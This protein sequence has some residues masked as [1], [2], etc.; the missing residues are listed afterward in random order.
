[1]GDGTIEFEN[2]K[3]IYR[4]FAGVEGKYNQPGDRNFCVLIDP[5]TAEDLRRDGWNVRQL[6][7]REE[8]DT[9]QDILQVSVNFKGRVPPYVVLINSKGRLVLDEE[10]VDILDQ[11]DIDTVDM[12]I[13]PYRWSIRGQEGIAAYVKMMYVKINEHKFDLKYADLELLPTRSG[14]VSE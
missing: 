10:M 11:L 2:A 3:I 6:R 7:A 8:T 1:M 9:P 13:N 12:V 5:E 14:K 4:N